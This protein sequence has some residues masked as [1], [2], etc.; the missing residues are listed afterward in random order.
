VIAAAGFLTLPKH[1]RPADPAA[2]SPE[3]TEVTA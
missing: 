3:P 2:A 1:S